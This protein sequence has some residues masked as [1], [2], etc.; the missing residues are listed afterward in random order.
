MLGMIDHGARRLYEA[1]EWRL[2]SIIERLT[3]MRAGDPE[4][5]PYCAISRSLL[6]ASDA[7]SLYQVEHGRRRFGR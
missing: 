7:Q 6:L 1:A 4:L 2:R 5:N 3:A